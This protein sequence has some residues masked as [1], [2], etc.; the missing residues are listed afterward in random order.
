MKYEIEKNV[1]MPP[2]GASFHPCPYPFSDM[3]MGD[4]FFIASKE[5]EVARKAVLNRAKNYR[6]SY[7]AD[8]AIETRILDGGVRVWRVVYKPK[9]RVKKIPGDSYLHLLDSK[10]RRDVKRRLV[11]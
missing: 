7:Q 11:G 6:L 8:F 10:S 3:E 9:P 4:S 2:H 1:V 5:P